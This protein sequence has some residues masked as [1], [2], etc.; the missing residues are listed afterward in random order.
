MLMQVVIRLTIYL[1][2]AIVRNVVEGHWYMG[3]ESMVS[4]TSVW[5]SSL[6]KLNNVFT[7]TVI[8]R[9]LV[10]FISWKEIFQHS[11][12]TSGNRSCI[13]LSYLILRVKLVFE[14]RKSN[15]LVVWMNIPIV[16]LCTYLK[17][18]R[19]ADCNV[20]VSY[21]GKIQPA[22]TLDDDIAH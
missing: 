5:I 9:I 6:E 13:I 2:Q 8:R 11:L 12:Q 15:K 17:C 10:A 16:Y 4:F 3:I 7:S 1:D 14:L 19:Y 21:Q 22:P 18:M 20:V